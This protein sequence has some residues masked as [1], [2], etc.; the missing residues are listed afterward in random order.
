M[1]YL[2][3]LLTVIVTITGSGSTEIVHVPDNFATLQEAIDNSST[4]DTVLVSDGIYTGEENKNLDFRGKAVVLKSHNGPRQ[5]VIDCEFVGRGFSFQSGEG[6]ETRL[7][8]LTIRNGNEG[9]GGAI[10]CFDASPVIS[11]CMIVANNALAGGGIFCSE[12]S[13]MVIDN[14]V[15]SGNWGGE[16]GGIVSR[17]RSSTIIRNCVISG[18]SASFNG[19]GLYCWTGNHIVE[20]S[21]LSG[22]S[23][24]RCGGG[25][26]CNGYSSEGWESVLTLTNC[27]ISDNQATGDFPYGYGGAINCRWHY[28]LVMTNCTVADN[29][30][31][32]LG[33]GIR[34]ESWAVAEIT[35]CI[36]W[37]DYPDEISSSNGYPGISYSDI[38]GG[39]PGEGNI[40][41]DPRFATYRGY[42][43]LLHPASPCVDGG[44]TSIEDSL[45]D[46]HP[47]WPE[48]Y[49]NGP[50]SDMGAY[51]GWGN[52]GW[53]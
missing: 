25:I 33:G 35:N 24:Q 1:K 49:P 11:N 53:L 18:N 32:A 28:D 6:P 47:K 23:A 14:C 41:E 52:S 5:T 17:A 27:I 3:T 46:W 50:E 4:G 42:G 30:A 13:G 51:G 19:G 15:V 34:C 45:Y 7:E 10:Y 48:W 22:N 36:L 31:S 8:G 12:F 9:N 26:Y 29:A 38:E 21:V 39:W 40:H 20:N 37:N 44:E 43:Y 2:F 16:G